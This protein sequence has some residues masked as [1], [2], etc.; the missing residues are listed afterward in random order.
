MT[1]R[2]NF[3]LLA[4]TGLALGAAGCR[5]TATPPAT[6]TAPDVLLAETG[7]GLV[8][9]TPQGTVDYGPAAVLSS[10]GARLAVVR[11]GVLS[12][13]ATGTGETIGTTG[14]PAGWLPRVASPDGR[15][16]ALSRTAESVVPQGR[17]RTSLLVVVDGRTREYD[18]PG[19][20][21]PDAFSGD[22]NALFVLEWQPSGAPD[23]YRVRV[24]DL[25]SGKVAPLNTR[26]KVPVPNGA[27]EQMRGEG[28]QAVAAGNLLLTLYTHQPGHRHTRDLLSGRPGN[29]H[30]FVHVLHLA[31]RW[32][33]CL[34][35]PHPFGE[36]PAAG[37]AIA[38]DAEGLAVVDGTSGQIAYANLETLTIDRTGPAQ[39]PAGTA[40][41]L[42]FTGDRRAL[43]GAGDRV[44]VLDRTSGA[45]TGGWHVPAPLL[46]LGLSRDGARVY[47]G[48]TGA[49]HW[50]DATTG[51]PLGQVEVQGL[52]TLRHVA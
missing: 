9:L 31:D 47:A 3:L 40:A 21:E 15:A 42:A 8:R 49:V 28:R 10:D 46:G 30:A 23:H 29:A 13:I 37:H 5:D 2:R 43:A 16:C 4:G 50:L 1:T 32:A 6:A 12:L 52:T 33:Y 19:V 20:V 48:T 26:A 17:E 24:L 36:G 39:I 25:G 18:L 41:A 11:E 38:A 27:E 45:V 14:V 22:A 44:S 35:L 51:T 34:D 7:R